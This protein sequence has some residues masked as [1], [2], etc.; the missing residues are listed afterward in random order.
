MTKPQL[1]NADIPP[2]LAG[3]RLD[4]ALAE[5]FPD[6]SR[7]RLQQWLR[8]GQVLVDGHQRRPRDKVLGGEEVVIT[9][10]PQ[11]EVSNLPQSI[12]LDIVYEDSALLVINKPA[13]LVVH[14]GAGNPQGTLLNALLHH[15]P[16]LANV[17]RAGIVH[18]LDKDTSG[19][20]V[21]ARNLIAQKALVEQL[22]A[23]SLQ[24][25]YEA[26]VAGVMTAGGRIETQL[27]RDPRARTRMSVAREG[28]GKLAITH[29]RVI[30]RFRAHTHVKLQLETGRTHQIRVH[31]AHIRH[32]II[33]DPDYGGRLRLPPGASEALIEAL[34]HFK[35]QALHAA[36]L[37]LVHPGTGETMQWTMHLPT[38]MRQLLQVL[39]EDNDANLSA[40]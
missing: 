31:M 34:R 14:P 8:A 29:Y 1:L 39:K 24:R 30:E 12:A 15:A 16:E 6:Y 9:L 21:V 27:G 10:T 22:Q 26:I 28:Q 13:G 33:G 5:L 23:H 37:G 40:P 32:P 11:Q 35:R 7:A 4:Q 25:G 17:P 20:L 19:L 36:S 18:R 2:E 3:R 38:D